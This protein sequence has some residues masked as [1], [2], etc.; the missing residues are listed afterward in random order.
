MREKLNA[1]RFPDTFGR[2]PHF[3]TEKEPQRGVFFPML[4]TPKA[5]GDRM[6]QAARKIKVGLQSAKD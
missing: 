4:M 6:G 1:F 2:C 5:W 3:P